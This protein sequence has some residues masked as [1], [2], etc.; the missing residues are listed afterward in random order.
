MTGKI[1]ILSAPSGTGK[2]TI[3]KRLMEKPE[4]KLGFSISATSRAPRGGEKD[5]VDYF[6]LSCEEF[7]RRAERGEFVE[8]EEVYSGTCYG[9]LESEV[10][11]V[12]GS[13]RNLI[14]DVDVKGAL[15]IKR[16][17]GKE[18]LTI[19]VMPPSLGEL[20]RRL[21]GRGTDSAETIEKRLAKA[22]YEIGHAPEFDATVVNDDI[23]RAVGEIEKKIETL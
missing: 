9:T 3:I 4:L 18:A 16:R 2:S 6:F 14:M 17:Y 1:I 20:R 22:E 5:G 13:G 11:R 21:E 19:F 15:N 12:T 8:W 7:R 23:D 10:A